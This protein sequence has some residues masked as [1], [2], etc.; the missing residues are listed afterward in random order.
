[1]EQIKRGQLA[2]RVFVWRLGDLDRHP[3]CANFICIKYMLD[4]KWRDERIRG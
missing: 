1:M 2:G 4:A 3:I